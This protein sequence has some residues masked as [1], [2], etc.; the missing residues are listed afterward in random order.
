V[1]TFA[2]QRLNL[3][4]H[5]SILDFGDK[6]T[7]KTGKNTQFCSEDVLFLLRKSMSGVYSQLALTA[8]EAE[9]QQS[10]IGDFPT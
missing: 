9:A 6:I 5:L 1:C 2:K 7:Q 4:F 8:M 3:Y 10:G